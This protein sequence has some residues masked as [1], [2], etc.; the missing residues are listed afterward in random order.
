MCCSVWRQSG[1]EGDIPKDKQQQSRVHWVPH[2]TVHAGRDQLCAIAGLGQ[3]GERV[4]Q[5]LQR[6]PSL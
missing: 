5:V 2:V 3:G 1:C 6:Q 4:S